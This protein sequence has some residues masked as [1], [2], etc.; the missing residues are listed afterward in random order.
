M[1]NLVNYVHWKIEIKNNITWAYFDKDNNAVNTINRDVL[2]ELEKIIIDTDQ[3]ANNTLGLVIASNKKT[4]FIAGADIEQ[5]TKIS[6]SEEGFELIRYGQEVFNQLENMHKPTLALING[7]CVGG[8]CELV[9]ACKY[10]IAENS[11]KTRIGL[12]EILLGIH[13]GWGG[14]VRLP[15]LIGGL[16]AMPLILSGRTLSASAAKKLGLIDMAVPER[17]L[18]STVNYYFQN[19]PNQQ[20]PGVVARLSNGY[21]AR[22]FLAKIMQKQ[23]AKKANIKHYP[24]PYAAI[25]QWKNHGVSNSAYVPEAKSIAKLFMTSTAKNLIRV[26]FLQTQLKSLAKNTK[27]NINHV[28]VI[29]AGTMGGDIAAWCALNNIKTTLHDREIKF[30]APAIARAEKL[31]K[32][33]LKAPHLIQ[34]ALDNLIPDVNGEGAKTADL[35]I[36]AIFEDVK[37][38][39]DLFKQLESQAKPE[40]ILATN[41]SSIPLDEINTVLVNPER[42]VGIHFFNPVSQMQLV[43]VVTGDKTSEEIANKSI[44][45]V[46]QIKRLP[47]P[48]KSSPG[49]VVNRILLPYLMESVLLIDEGFNKESIDKAAVDFGMPMGPIV[50]A[51]TVGLDVCLSVAKELIKHYGGEVPQ[52][53]IDQVEQKN[54]GKKSGK[55]FYD[56]KNGK[57]IKSKNIK[58][59]SQ[60]DLTQIQERLVYRMLNE[61]AACLREGVIESADLLD[62]GMIF[63]TGFAPFTGGPMNYARTESHSKVAEKLKGLSS[64]FGARFNLDAYWPS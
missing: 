9:L 49:F 47:L 53:L 39:Q 31:Y 57:L 4:G 11:P 61:A 22:I 44:C 51:D 21:L 12:P 37:T 64:K 5:F 6:D 10:R 62:A 27:N 1:S 42:L 34:A 46:K 45:F 25:E 32:K 7:F 23:V 52:C 35:I 43:E 55:G 2:A 63:G 36:E 54:L 24:A 20:K 56:Y 40:A 59:A 16:K 30:I 60:V 41:T 17:Q 26:F 8:G 33:K 48:V 28:H 18:E 3:S 29:G 13:P 14:T 50:L 15:K 58:L 38:K 19:K